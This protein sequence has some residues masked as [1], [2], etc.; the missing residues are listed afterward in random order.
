[1]GAEFEKQVDVSRMIVGWASTGGCVKMG[2]TFG[3]LMKDRFK[4]G[5]EDRCAGAFGTLTVHPGPVSEFGLGS[6]GG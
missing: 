2:D 4:E 5:K 3:E 6:G 1:M